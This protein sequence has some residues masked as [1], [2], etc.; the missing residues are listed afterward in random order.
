MSIGRHDILFDTIYSLLSCDKLFEGYFFESLEEHILSGSSGS[1][2]NRN[3]SSAT[4]S[5]LAHHIP[6]V[7]LRAFIDY[8]AAQ[9]ALHASLEKCLLHFDVSKIDLH[10]VMQM[11]RRHA[12]WD[13][14]IY[15]HN[16]AFK[17]YLT[18]FEELVK[19][20]S[21]VEFL[22]LET[23]KHFLKSLDK[24]RCAEMLIYFYFLIFDDLSL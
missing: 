15:L 17:D 11:C 7:I 22:T 3:R 20:M 18:P 23:A 2:L 6:P 1:G 5:T 9:P 8:Y 24:E 4:A 14:F 21:P 10:S 19:M 13:A 16:T 12:L